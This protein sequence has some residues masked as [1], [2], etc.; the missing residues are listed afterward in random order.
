MAAPEAKSAAFHVGAHKTATTMLQNFLWD[1]RAELRRRG[2]SLIGRLE[3]TR[4]VGLGP[5]LLADPGPFTRRVDDFRRSPNYTLL[6]A[7]DEQIIGQPFPPAGDGRIYPDARRNAA[8]L[9][10]ILAPLPTRI[11]IMLRPQDQFVESYYLQ[12][13]QGGGTES[14]AQYLERVDLDALSW[15]PVI[16]ALTDAFGADAVTVRDFGSIR[17]GQE[18]FITGFLR[19]LDERLDLDPH[20]P[21]SHN[22][23]LSERGVR[24]ALDANAILRKPSD[25]VAVR[26]FL[27]LHFSNAA[28]ARPRFFS[29]EQ[30]QALRD[31]YADEYAELVAQ[32]E[33]R[34]AA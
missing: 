3:M 20:Y 6:L 8:A 23:G 4:D 28:Y 22:R 33:P 30:K 7:S 12:T 21:G 34:P 1:R 5:A 29:D 16:A 24:M 11:V 10:R 25:V 17:D 32:P 19:A 13:V 18:Q 2:V 15:R 14:F 27:Q 9:A 31:R 26:D